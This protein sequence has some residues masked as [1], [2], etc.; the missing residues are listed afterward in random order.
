MSTILITDIETA[1]EDVGR[2][3][4]AMRRALTAMS[5]AA[6][7]NGQKVQLIILAAAAELAGDKASMI[8]G[9]TMACPPQSHLPR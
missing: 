9:L 7:D 2:I 1:A 6:N 8:E 5:E 3:A 4:C